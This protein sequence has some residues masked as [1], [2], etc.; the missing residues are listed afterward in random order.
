MTVGS[1]ARGRT[2]QIFFPAPVAAH[3]A[4]CAH[5]VSKTLHGVE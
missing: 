1:E 3:R 2:V 4:L 5:T